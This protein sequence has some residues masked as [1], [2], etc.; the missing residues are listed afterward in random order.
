MNHLPFTPI[1][2]Q[3]FKVYF[4]PIYNVAN[5]VTGDALDKVF[6][7]KDGSQMTEITDTIHQITQDDNS[8]LSRHRAYVTLTAEEM[9]ANAIILAIIS[10]NSSYD[11][12]DTLI[13]YTSGASGLS[14]QNGV[15]TVTSAFSPSVLT[16]IVQAINKDY[17][18]ANQDINN[19]GYNYYGL[20][21][22]VGKDT[23]WIIIR[24]KT[25]FTEVGYRQT[26]NDAGF[27]QAW[28]DRTTMSY[29]NSVI[30]KN[31]K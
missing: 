28:I 11:S 27:A 8:N 26:N 9:D 3:E 7:S 1:K 12:N 30:I 18:V 17:V 14:G 20:T 15:S 29:S 10:Q 2:G 22:R 16:T 13:I 25:D 5:N 21:K 23:L 6:I 24:E 31:G 19:G 4:S